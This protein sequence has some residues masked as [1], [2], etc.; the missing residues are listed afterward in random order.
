MQSNC[1]QTLSHVWGNAIKCCSLLTV[2][3]SSVVNC[4]L[5][6][7]VL[8]KLKMHRN[9]SWDYAIR[10]CLICSFRIN[11][12]HFKIDLTLKISARHHEMLEKL[13]YSEF[14]LS[15][16][17]EGVILYGQKWRV[18]SHLSFGQYISKILFL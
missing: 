12:H 3:A 5:D 18:E 8:I 7:N 17:C 9:V 1:A 11:C 6:K 10:R 13:V 4:C 2:V 15:K 14:L 16:Q